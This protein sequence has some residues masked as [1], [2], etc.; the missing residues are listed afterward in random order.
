[1]LN[2]RS[3]VDWR[4]DYGAPAGQANSSIYLLSG[5][6]K[7]TTALSLVCILLNPHLVCLM[8]WMRHWTMRTSDVMQML[9][10]CRNQCNSS[11]S[12]TTK[13]RWSALSN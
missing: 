13:L 12:L 10:R 3:V 11:A 9:P 7:A 8:R 5:G 6:E 1:M 4:N 2:D